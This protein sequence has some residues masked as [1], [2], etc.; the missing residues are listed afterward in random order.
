[1]ASN[2]RNDK[3]HLNSD[4]VPLR[5]GC[6]VYVVGSVKVHQLT[7]DNYKSNTFKVLSFTIFRFKNLK[8]KKKIKYSPAYKGNHNRTTIKQPNAL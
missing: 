8:K 2:Y 7:I 3:Q 1:M 4:T 6:A 5:L